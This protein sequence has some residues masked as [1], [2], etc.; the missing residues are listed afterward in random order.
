MGHR[1]EEPNPVA[2]GDR[3]LSE[4]VSGGRAGWVKGRNR[5]EGC[6]SVCVREITSAWVRVHVGDCACV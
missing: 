2:T 1:G 6:K 4:R 3:G 5:G